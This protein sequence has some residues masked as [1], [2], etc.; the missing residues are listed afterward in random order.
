[1]Q[2]GLPSDRLIAEW[3]LKSL[4]VKRA[5]AG[6]SVRDARKKPAA[7]VEVPA[8]IEAVVKSNVEEARRWQVRVREQLQAGFARKLV[9]TGFVSDQNSAHY[10]LDPYEN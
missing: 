2:Q 6:R 5:I 10:L 9:V 3:W 1:M 8:A 7:E 4:R